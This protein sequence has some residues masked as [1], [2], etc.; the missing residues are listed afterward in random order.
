MIK[1][2][3]AKLIG[4]LSQGRF[5]K[6]VHE[7]VECKEYCEFLLNELEHANIAIR[8]L[9]H[10][11][12]GLSLGD[13]MQTR[14]SF[15]YQWKDFHKGVAMPDDQEFMKGIEDRICE[16]TSFPREWFPGKKVV[17]VGCGCS[18]FSN[19]LLKLGASVLSCDQSDWALSRTADIC[20][21][22][23][24]KHQVRKIDLLSW[25]EPG[26][27]DLAF[28][29]GV[30]HHTGNTYL[31]VENVARK[32]RPGGRIFLMLYGYPSNIDEVKTLNLYEE[33]RHA[34]DLASFEEKK[35][36]VVKKYGEH[37]GHGMFDAIS[38]RIN[39]LL[40]FNEAAALLERLGFAN[41][42]P[43]IKH[44]NHHLVA[45]KVATCPSPAV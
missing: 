41:V 6:Q 11:N 32:V 42:R 15:D 31:A 28:C 43:T 40:S 4:L 8:H 2:L 36:L 17:D 13:A 18:R 21:D 26:D 5:F 25:S 9:Y 23:G 39:E 22:F 34:T 19:G 29:F 14:A 33:L 37:I 3:G 45:D 35:K 20:R 7:S 16:F 10:M 38:P 44:R 12:P 30:A 1:Q 24:G 27:F